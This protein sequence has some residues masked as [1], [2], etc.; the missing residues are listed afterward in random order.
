MSE[1][2]ESPTLLFSHALEAHVHSAGRYRSLHLTHA[3]YTVT[4][5]L[6]STPAPVTAGVAVL[7]SPVNDDFDVSA[8]VSNL[9]RSFTK[10]IEKTVKVTD[11]AVKDATFSFKFPVATTFPF[12]PSI[13]EVFF[14]VEFDPAKRAVAEPIEKHFVRSMITAILEKNDA[15]ETFKTPTRDTAQSSSETPPPPIPYDTL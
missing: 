9:M 8:A 4:F 1:P 15:Y 14:N 13:F 7:T 2:S 6:K 11:C 5:G 10:D 12:A 3:T